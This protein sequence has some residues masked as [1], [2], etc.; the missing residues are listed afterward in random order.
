M[1]RSVE[2]WTKRAPEDV[3]VAAMDHFGPRGAGL[4]LAKRGPL[5]AH[6]DSPIGAVSVTAKPD[7]AH[8]RTNV[9]IIAKELDRDVDQ[10]IAWLT[11]QTPWRDVWRWLRRRLRDLANLRG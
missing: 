8:R 1:W 7:P 2:I 10:F 9:E 5:E 4:R 6:F 3:I 11:A